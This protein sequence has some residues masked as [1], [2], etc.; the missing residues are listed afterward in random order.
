MTRR[1][2]ILWSIFLIFMV[3]NPSLLSAKDMVSEFLSTDEDCTLLF[4]KKIMLKGI[5]SMCNNEVT[6][7]VE[8]VIFNNPVTK[9]FEI[10]VS[11]PIISSQLFFDRFLDVIRTDT[12]FP[13]ANKL[14][15]KKTGYDKRMYFMDK[16]SKNPRDIILKYN[17]EGKEKKK[18]TIFSDRNTFP[19][20]S[21]LLMYQTLLLK[22]IKE[23]F[24]FDIISLDDALKIR[25]TAKYFFTDDVLSLS[26]KFNFPKGI[27]KAVNPGIK[28]HVFEM[29]TYGLIDLFVQ[30][31]WYCVYKATYPY[32][33]VA[34]WGG[35]G[36]NTETIYMMETKTEFIEK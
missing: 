5:V 33:F 14:L 26:K 2:I 32:E 21:V 16:A 25:M 7:P 18:K 10:T 4:P 12:A 23:G 20:D 36:I 31:S 29:K 1:T 27:E 34:Y 28:Y 24:Y 17:M 9:N 15:M 13:S 3:S 30:S 8:M 6:G 22:N 11:S 19:S 35:N